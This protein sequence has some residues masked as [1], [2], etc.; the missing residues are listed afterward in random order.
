MRSSQFWIIV[1]SNY[2][3][4]PTPMVPSD[5]D[6]NVNS[7]NEASPFAKGVALSARKLLL[8][9]LPDVSCREK[10]LYVLFVI[11]LVSNVEI[12]IDCNHDL[13]PFYATVLPGYRAL[14]RM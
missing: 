5:A 8:L 14:L 12:W 11:V 6:E 4:V 10:G 7:H 2:T 1:L 13:C 3:A 9:V